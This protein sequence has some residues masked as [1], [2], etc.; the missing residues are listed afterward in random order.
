MECKEIYLYYFSKSKWIP[1]VRID[2]KSS[3]SL[4]LDGGMGSIQQSS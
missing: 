3:I 1:F 2:K 4:L